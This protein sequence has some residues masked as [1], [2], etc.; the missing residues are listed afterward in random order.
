MGTFVLSHYDI[1]EMMF[2][3]ADIHRSSLDD[4]IMGLSPPFTIRPRVYNSHSDGKNKANT[5]D[6]AQ[7]SARTGYATVHSLARGE[8]DSA[9]HTRSQRRVAV[10]KERIPR[11]VRFA[12]RRK[13]QK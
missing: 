2:H 11:F 4:L 12:A 7:Q 3:S 9:A 5:F 8:R 10:L 6:T 13:K 1:L